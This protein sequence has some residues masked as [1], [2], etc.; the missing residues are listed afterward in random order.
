[1]KLQK[2]LS[3]KVKGKSYS[4]WVVTI[5]PSSI[6]KLKWSEGQQL[7]AEIIDGKL[8]LKSARTK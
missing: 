5:P 7:E 8:V 2:Q 1:M 4:K 3:R 6:D